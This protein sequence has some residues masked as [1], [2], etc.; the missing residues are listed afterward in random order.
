M[1]KIIWNNLK[2]KDQKSSRFLST[3]SALCTSTAI[4]PTQSR[5]LSLTQQCVIKESVTVRKVTEVNLNR[6][7]NCFMST[8]ASVIMVV[9]TGL[10]FNLFQFFSFMNHSSVFQQSV[11]LISLC[12]RLSRSFLSRSNISVARSDDTL[13]SPALCSDWQTYCLYKYKKTF[14]CRKVKIFIQLH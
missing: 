10:G 3:N 8:P 6:W 7:E 1:N 5:N 9:L 4:L 13:V 2:F 12:N 11:R 14:S